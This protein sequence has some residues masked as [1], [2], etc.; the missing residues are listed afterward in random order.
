MR[1]VVMEAL[2]VAFALAGV[3]VAICLALLVFGGEAAW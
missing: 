2:A 1:I 3:A